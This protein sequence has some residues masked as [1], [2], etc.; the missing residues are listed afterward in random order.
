VFRWG[1]YKSALT[2]LGKVKKGSHTT[3]AVKPL[4]DWPAM[5]R[6]FQA[7]DL[8]VNDSTFYFVEVRK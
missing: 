3:L 6:E 8:P 4:N 5:Q 1:V 2:G 7:D